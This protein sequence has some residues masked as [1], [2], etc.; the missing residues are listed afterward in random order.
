MSRIFNRVLSFRVEGEIYDTK[1]TTPESIIKN[2]IWSFKYNDEDGNIEVI[3]HH[4]DHRGRITK[5]V[6][7]PKIDKWKT[8][9]T[10]AFI[11]M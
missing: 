5:I 11:K 3:G 1:E 9:D 2:Y 4:R 10:E 7:L 8:P 6:K